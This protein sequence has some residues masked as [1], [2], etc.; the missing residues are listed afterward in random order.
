MY[1]IEFCTENQ[2][3]EFYAEFG[4]TDETVKRDVQSLIKWL[5][6]EPHLPNVTG[7]CDL[8]FYRF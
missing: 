1:D 3:R 2:I 4:A 7:T 6:N 8:Q 5:H